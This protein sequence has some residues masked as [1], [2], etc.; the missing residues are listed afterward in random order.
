MTSCKLYKAGCTTLIPDTP[1]ENEKCDE[2]LYGE[3]GDQYV[4]C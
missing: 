4:G 1:I 2:N 3:R